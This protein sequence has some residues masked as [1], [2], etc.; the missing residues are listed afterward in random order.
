MHAAQVSN[1]TPKTIAHRPQS[2]RFSR[3]ESPREFAR[4]PQPNDL[5]RC[6]R[7]SAKPPLLTTAKSHCLQ[8]RSRSTAHVERPNPLWPI[9]LMCR[10]RED[11]KRTTADI[12]GDLADNL[13][14]IAMKSHAAFSADCANGRNVLDHA[15]L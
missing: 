13:S 1:P 5:V 9:H 2:H 11:I 15:N 3:L 7:A 8:Q 14:A 12:Y 4:S 6:Q 10:K